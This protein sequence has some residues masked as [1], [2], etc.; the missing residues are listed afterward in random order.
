MRE[1]EKISEEGQAKQT[2]H[3]SKILKE[4][5]IDNLVENT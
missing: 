1:T 5:S 4:N 3:L 2:K